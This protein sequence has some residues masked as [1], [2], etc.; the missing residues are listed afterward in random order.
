MPALGI[1]KIQIKTSL[2][3]CISDDE[4]QWIANIAYVLTDP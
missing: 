3:E 2:A 4:M 1:H